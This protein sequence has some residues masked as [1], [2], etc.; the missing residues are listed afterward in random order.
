MKT[1]TTLA[2]FLLA[3]VISSAIAEAGT[4]G[5]G[6]GRSPEEKAAIVTATS[7]E[8]VAA[9]NQKVA[10]M[11]CAAIIIASVIGAGTYVSLQIPAVKKR[12]GI[13]AAKP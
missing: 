11:Y 9:S 6:Y 13:T 3:S 4:Y 1:K 7:N 5:Y 8:R 10:A 12:L 2:V